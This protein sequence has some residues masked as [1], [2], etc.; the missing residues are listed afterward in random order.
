MPNLGLQGSVC[1]LLL[2]YLPVRA[3]ARFGLEQIICQGKQPTQCLLEK[4]RQLLLIVALSMKRLESTCVLLLAKSIPLQY[5]KKR[6]GP[7]A[8]CLQQ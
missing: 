2:Q 7:N 5:I 3:E 8:S 4:K 6:D 1:V